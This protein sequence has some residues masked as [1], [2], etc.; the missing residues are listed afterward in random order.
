M[1]SI[2]VRIESLGYGGAGVARV[3]GRVVFV[4]YSAPGDTL[5]VRVVEDRGSYLKAEMLEILEPGPRRREPR[6]RHFGRCGGCTWQHVAYADQLAAK[7][8]ILR[9]SVRRIGGAEPTISPIV[10]SPAEWGYRTRTRLRLEESGVLGYLAAGTNSLVEVE[11]CPILDPRLSERIPQLRSQ[12]SGGLH[13]SLSGSPARAARAAGGGRAGPEAPPAAELSLEVDERG[14]LSA[15]FSSP[16][17]PEE[18]GGLGFAQAN[19]GINRRLQEL[20]RGCIEESAGASP[21][22]LD[23][24]CGDG[25]LSLPLVERAGR[26]VGFDSSEAAIR[27]ARRRAAE[28]GASRADYR[29][30]AVEAS[31]GAIQGLAKE[32]DCLILDPPR[33]GLKELAGFIAALGVPLV[34]YVSCAPPALARDLRAFESAG[35]R[36]EQLQPLDMFPQSYHLETIA[37]L[38]RRA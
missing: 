5:R 14:E 19:R 16:V 33:R 17:E 8:A 11:E 28:M 4:P 12:Y 30:A 7:E 26:I 23:L 9:E 25:N 18:A 32:S 27:R 24:Y 6:C 3:E 10:A 1:E 22:L 20:V 15:S 37:V 38:T 13:R 21:T 29:C 36:I 35:Y 2:T 34:L 31:R